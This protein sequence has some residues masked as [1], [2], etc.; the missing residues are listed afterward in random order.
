MSSEYNRTMNAHRFFQSK[1]N[2]N[3]YIY[4]LFEW[5]KKRPKEKMSII[6]KTEKKVGRVK[7]SNIVR[8]CYF[9]KCLPGEEARLRHIE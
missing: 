6:K 7:M 8:T 3:V 9:M 4:T 1:C 2:L 5:Y